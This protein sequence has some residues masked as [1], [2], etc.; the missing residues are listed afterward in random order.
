MING[1]ERNKFRV[2]VG[3]DAGLLDK[4]YRIN[5]K[6]AVNLIVKKM[7]NLIT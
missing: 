2:L 6:F 4:L 1:I 7:S 5:P 3:S